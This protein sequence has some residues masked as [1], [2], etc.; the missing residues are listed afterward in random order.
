VVDHLQKPTLTL[1]GKTRM[2]LDHWAPVFHRRQVDI[3]RST[4][5]GCPST[6]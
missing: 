4:A 5:R 1:S 6:A 2:V 3:A